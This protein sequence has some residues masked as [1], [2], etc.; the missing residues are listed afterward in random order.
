MIL[1]VG[2]SGLAGNAFFHVWLNV[3]GLSVRRFAAANPRLA[4]HDEI[5]PR[6]ILGVEGDAKC[7]TQLRAELGVGE[8]PA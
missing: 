7:L 4:G 3:T 6:H 2:K 1:T 8:I 5:L